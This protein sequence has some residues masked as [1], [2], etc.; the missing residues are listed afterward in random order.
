MNPEETNTP[1]LEAMRSQ[2][3]QEIEERW[4]RELTRNPSLAEDDPKV[5]YADLTPEEEAEINPEYRTITE[6]DFR[7]RKIRTY[8][9]NFSSNM[10]SVYNNYMK[11]L[12]PDYIF[13]DTH[14]VY[15]PLEHGKTLKQYEAEIAEA[16]RQMN[17]SVEDFQKI[18]AEREKTTYGAP[19]LKYQETLLEIFTRLRAM[20][21]NAPKFDQQT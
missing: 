13:T 7:S 5:I 11:I 18:E 8:L 3:N 20:N 9:Y 16:M 14:T 2:V 17:L 19:E 12:G 1:E 21:P 15:S 4:Q 6:A 10:P